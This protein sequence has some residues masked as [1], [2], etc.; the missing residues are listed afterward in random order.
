[1]FG[2]IGRPLALAGAVLAAAL[3]AAPFGAQALED[4]LV[5]VTSYPP[6]TTG[7]VKKAFE[8]LSGK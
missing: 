1:M 4:T 5:I 2:A 3:I 7:T 8:T 6:D